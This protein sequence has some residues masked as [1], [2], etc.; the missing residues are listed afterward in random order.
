MN[1]MTQLLLLLLLRLSLSSVIAC[2]TSPI[3]PS[4]LITR[5]AVHAPF[6][7]SPPRRAGDGPCG[8][9]RRNE[10]R[11]R[12]DATR[13]R[14]YPRF[15]SSILARGLYHATSRTSRLASRISLPLTL[16]ARHSLTNP[17]TPYLRPNPPR[18]L[19]RRRDRAAQLGRCLPRHVPRA[20]W[21]R[22]GCGEGPQALFGADH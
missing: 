8:E 6:L 17:G 1:F 21:Q 15:S 22:D 18:R 4:S 16:D 13:R 10:R 3:Q 9:L 5:H 11:G 12:N 7:G 20:G 14:I 2:I 19:L